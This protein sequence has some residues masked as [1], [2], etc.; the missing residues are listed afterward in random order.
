MH[1]EVD[2]GDGRALGV[3]ERERRDHLVLAYVADLDVQLG[4][5]MRLREAIDL[6]VG[7]EA[8]V[9]LDRAQLD[10]AHLRVH[11]VAHEARLSVQIETGANRPGSPPS[12]TCSRA[13]GW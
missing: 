1:L 5:V 8:S 7:G 4:D 3:E 13:D 6:L 10:H 11:V 2:N 12:R 9:G